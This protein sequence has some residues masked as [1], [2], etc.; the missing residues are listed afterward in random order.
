MTGKIIYYWQ[1]YLCDVVITSTQKL[2]TKTVMFTAI[3]AYVKP[4]KN[5]LVNTT[6]S[7][8][9]RRQLRTSFDQAE[10]IKT[11]RAQ[12]NGLAKFCAWM[13]KCILV[14]NGWSNLYVLYFKTNYVGNRCPTGDA[15]TWKH[16]RWK[17]ICP[18]ACTNKTKPTKHFVKVNTSV[19]LCTTEVNQ[20]TLA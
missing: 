17:W 9:I 18:A 11:N 2:I 14:D 19:V 5:E 8:F 12:A 6:G 16:F 20:Q 7:S 10:A 13:R 3:F 4:T 15:M 1:L